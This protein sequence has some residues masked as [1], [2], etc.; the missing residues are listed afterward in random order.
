MGIELLDHIVMGDDNFVSLKEKGFIYNRRNR[1]YDERWF[2][3]RMK[4][5]FNTF[6]S[7]DKVTYEAHIFAHKDI[8]D[9]IVPV[10]HLNQLPNPLLLQSYLYV[11]RKEKEWI[12][13]IV[14]EENTGKLLYEI[15]LK[16]GKATVYELYVD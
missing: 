11:D 5:L 13:G 2:I 8:D 15:W 1:I 6:V 9:S 12:A 3:E 7:K 14:I 16:N 4:R 10:E